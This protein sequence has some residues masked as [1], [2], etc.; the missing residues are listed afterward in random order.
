MTTQ[1]QI[2]FN[3]PPEYVVLTCDPVDDEPPVSS[4]SMSTRNTSEWRERFRVD[5]WGIRRTLRELYG[6]GYSDVSVL[7]ERAT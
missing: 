1:Q 6:Q 5:K 3:E 7:V 2:D 4:L